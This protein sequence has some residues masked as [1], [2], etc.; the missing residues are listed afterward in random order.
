[1]FSVPAEHVLLEIIAN[2]GIVGDKSR[3]QQIKDCGDHG[4]PRA[5]ESENLTR[6]RVEFRVKSDAGGDNSVGCWLLSVG[7]MLD[8]DQVVV[9]K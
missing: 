4:L 3:S 5:S 7:E 9:E 6:S 8:D 1:M 2:V